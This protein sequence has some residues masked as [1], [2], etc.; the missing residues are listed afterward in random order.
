M[1]F[2]NFIEFFEQITS[3]YSDKPAISFKENDKYYTISGN[4]LRELVYAAAQSLEKLGIKYGEKAAIISENRFEWVVADF[5]CIIL[6]VVTVPVYTTMTSSQIKYILSHSG[7]RICFVSTQII[8]NKIASIKNELPE[9][10]EVICF[11]EP[12]NSDIKVISFK[13][14]ISSDVSE[15][16]SD[17]N[18]TSA[19]K[20]LKEKSINIKPDDLLTIIYT[21]GT[22]G[23]PKGVC[24]THKNILSN[25]SQ[26]QNVLILGF[27]DRF[28]S[29]LPLAHSYERTAGYYYPLSVGAHIYY[30]VSVDTLQTQMTEV[31]PTVITTVPN[32]FKR[33]HSRILSNI[34]SSPVHKKII[35]KKSLK[36]GFKYR[37]NKTHFLWKLADKIVFKKI[38]EKTGGK[39]KFFISGGSALSNYHAEFFD[40]IGITILQG[41]GLTEASPVISVNPPQKNKIGTVGPALKGIEVKTADDGEILIKGSNVMNG[42][43]KNESDTSEIIKDG[44]LHTGDIGNIDKDG[45]ITI[46][47]R[48]KQLI[49]TEG[50][51]YISLAH[52]EDTISNSEIIEQVI[53]VA[54]DDKPFV[55]ALIYPDYDKI[56]NALNLQEENLE[57]LQG[58]HNVKKIVSEEINRLQKDF[59]KY[60]RVRK[61]KLLTKPFTIENGDLTPTLKVKRKIVE[62]KYKY[63]IDELYKL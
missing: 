22:T 16:N 50:G 29:F 59:A 15:G 38:R 8:A 57:L 17:Y 6:G 32:L 46:T 37:N 31:K 60:E 23:I 12:N 25:I 24:L 4:K 11:N 30:A 26:C 41:Y 54:D 42:Y 51:K 35:A 5:A 58:N 45:Y 2:S 39:L 53:A 44:W 21:S 10:K 7:C 61:F 63:L 34:E 40:S 27:E 13:K 18:I 52:I 55:A 47:D 19:I 48:K 28:L 62:E 43:Y 33:I 36:L 9:L 1:I 49:K 56:K 20:Y 3:N 14:L